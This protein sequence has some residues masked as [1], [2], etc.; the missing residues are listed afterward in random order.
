MD[1]LGVGVPATL[2]LAKGQTLIMPNFAA[3]WFGFGLVDRLQAATGLPSFLVNDAR[4]FV[5]AESVLGAARDYRDVFGVVLGT[6]VGGGV[7]LGKALHLGE[8]ALAGEIGHHIVDPFGVRC[9]CGSTGCLETVASATAL[10][11]SVTRAYLQGRSPVLFE[12]T[13]GELGA[14]DAAE[15][16]RAARLG[17][18]ACLEALHRVGFY[19]G[20]ATANVTTLFAPQCIVV[21]GGLAGASDILFP[22]ITATWQKHLRVVGRHQPELKVAE[23]EHGGVV[24]AALY[25]KNALSS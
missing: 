12:L 14:V 20:V 13:G 4:A 7:V 19:L 25:A 8:G 9:G 2:D 21:G 16:A 22:V 17:D 5:L 1:A 23:L 6:G 3:G 15:I 10:V 11:A 18:E 24:G